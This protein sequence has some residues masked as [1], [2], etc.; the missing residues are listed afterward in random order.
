MLVLSETI[1]DSTS[2][3]YK[4]HLHGHMDF[5]KEFLSSHTLNFIVH[6]ELEWLLPKNFSPNCT[7]FKYDDNELLDIRLPKYDPDWWSQFELSFY[8]HIFRVCIPALTLQDVPHTHW[9]KHCC[10]SNGP[11]VRT[12]ETTFF[13]ILP[14]TSSILNIWCSFSQ[15]PLMCPLLKMSPFTLLNIKRKV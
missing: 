5:V 14:G 12:Q 7:V 8:P 11:H 2:F 3:S 13:S 10:L 1:L 15:F 4:T 6:L 9:S